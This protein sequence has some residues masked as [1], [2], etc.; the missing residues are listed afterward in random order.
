MKAASAQALHWT[1]PQWAQRSPLVGLSGP[2]VLQRWQGER[3]DGG[4]IIL[5][6]F[7]ALSV[8]QLVQT[9]V[10]QPSA[11]QSFSYNESK[12]PNNIPITFLS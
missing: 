3:V 7:E 5:D 2:V 10:T 6:G 12:Y 1:R 4:L 11:I 8:Y 9:L